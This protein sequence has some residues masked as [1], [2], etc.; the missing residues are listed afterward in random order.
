[1]R[2]L[3]QPLTLAMALLALLLL[4]AV[5]LTQTA[6]AQP[7][8]A[9]PPRPAGAGALP[10]LSDWR[11]APPG[12]APARPAP[13]FTGGQPAQPGRPPVQGAVSPTPA[14]GPGA[15]HILLV[16]ADSTGAPAQLQAALQAQPGVT[17]V[18]LFDAN[19]G[20]P[21]LAQ[22]Q[23][24]Q[25]VAAMSNSPFADATALGDNLADYVDGGG[26]AVQLGFSF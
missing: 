21:T 14:C 17:G 12:P 15:Y 3:R 6:G 4:A 7:R 24:Y 8:S 25:V 9:G 13:A 20:T 19:A 1:M 26:V 22:L 5:A 11:A 2:R 23:A 18:D 16:Y 10:R